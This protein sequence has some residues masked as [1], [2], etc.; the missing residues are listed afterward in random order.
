MNDWS[1][2]N[3]DVFLKGTLVVRVTGRHDHRPKPGRQVTVHGCGF[4]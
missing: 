2:L 3:E 4:V 1:P